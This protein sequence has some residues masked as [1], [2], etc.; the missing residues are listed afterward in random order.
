MSNIWEKSKKWKYKRVIEYEYSTIHIIINLIALLTVRSL[1][2][3][4]VSYYE[5]YNNE[6]YDLLGTR[7]ADTLSS[8]GPDGKPES[9][10]A[11]RSGS[12]SYKFTLMLQ[13]TFSIFR[14]M[15]IWNV[16]HD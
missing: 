16:L 13:S 14:R 7:N 10:G 9:S 4:S 12:P 8:L 3:G 1:N 15:S 5:I 6:I 11:T 2:Y